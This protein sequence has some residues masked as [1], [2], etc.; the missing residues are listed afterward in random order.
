M[1]CCL[2]PYSAT[3]HSFD[4]CGRS[5]CGPSRSSDVRDRKWGNPSL[6]RGTE[7]IHCPIHC[8]N[9]PAGDQTS[10]NAIRPCISPNTKATARVAFVFGGDEEDRT[11][12]LRIANAT[13]SQLSYVPIIRFN[14]SSDYLFQR[15]YLAL[16]EETRRLSVYRIASAIHGSRNACVSGSPT[17]SG[18]SA[19]CASRW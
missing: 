10:A 1:T 6:I 8:T 3:A 11:P 13:L 9:G 18:L 4:V 19:S 2:P 5:L 12:D 17:S 14:I 15:N 16:F 7:A